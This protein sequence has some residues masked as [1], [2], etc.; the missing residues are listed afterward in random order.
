M[1]K[2]PSL[3][4][5]SAEIRSAFASGTWAEKFPPILDVELAA[6][7]ARVPVNT[8]YD[9]SSRGQLKGCARRVGKYLRVHRDRLVSLIFNEGINQ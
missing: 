6:E 5:T 8:I 1:Q 7:L 4:L 9:W 3:E 2:L